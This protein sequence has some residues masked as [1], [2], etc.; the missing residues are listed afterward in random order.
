MKPTF[1]FLILGM[2]LLA[3][4]AACSPLRIKRVSPPQPL[5]PTSTESQALLP[6]S[7]SPSPIPA[8]LTPVPDA[9]AT[10]IIELSEDLENQLNQLESQLQ[11]IDLVTDFNP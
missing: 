6:V 8:T 11:Q 5:Q 10:Q 9:A 7:A 1:R 2:L 3:S 4:L